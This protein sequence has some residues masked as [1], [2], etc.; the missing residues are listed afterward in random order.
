MIRISRK[1]SVYSGEDL[2][3]C[4]SGFS[5]YSL[6]QYLDGGALDFLLAGTP[7][8]LRELSVSLVEW[9]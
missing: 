5:L 8:L 2:E 7:V 6:L 9:G 4:L 3:G 1:G